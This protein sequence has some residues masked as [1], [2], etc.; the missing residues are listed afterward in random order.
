MAVRGDEVGDGNKGDACRAAQPD[1]LLL[2]HRHAAHKPL[3]ACRCNVSESNVLLHAF[4]PEFPAVIQQAQTPN[5]KPRTPNLLQLDRTAA[6]AAV[7]SKPTRY[8]PS[9]AGG[10]CVR[11]HAMTPYQQVVAITS[12]TRATKEPVAA[13]ARLSLAVLSSA[14]DD[15]A[16]HAVEQSNASV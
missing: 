13:G 12:N 11:V 14:A 8:E 7:R 5:P 10:K 15:A 16:S 3:V 6:A 2:F 4:F 9:H 1:L